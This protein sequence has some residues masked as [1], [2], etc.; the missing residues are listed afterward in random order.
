MRATAGRKGALVH[1]VHETRS[2]N[3]WKRFVPMCDP[4]KFINGEETAR[5]ATCRGCLRADNPFLWPVIIGVAFE[6]MA[7]GV[8]VLEDQWNALVTRDLAT[9]LSELT[10]RGKIIYADFVDGAAVWT[11]EGGIRHARPAMAARTWCTLASITWATTVD[12]YAK[13]RLLPQE[14]TCM[15]C[16]EIETRQRR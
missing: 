7:D 4:T 6:R 11:D 10:D 14:I 16:L 12:Q 8:V 5:A 9:P 13:L 15:R 2:K 1:I 3:H